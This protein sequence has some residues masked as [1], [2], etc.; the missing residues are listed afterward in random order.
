MSDFF[1]QFFG[2]LGGG[3]SGGGAQF[4]RRAGGGFS[5]F[6][7]G[8][9]REAQKAPD[10]NAEVEIALEDAIK[11]SKRRLE[12]TAQDDCPQCGGSGMVA[13]EE[14]QGKARIVRSTEPC[15]RCGGAGIIPAH[16]TLEVTIPPGVTE[17][18]RI[19]LKGQ[20]GKGPRADLNGDLFLTVRLASHPVFAATG[21]D[22]RCELP[23]WD[24][25]AALGAE[26]TA[27]TLNGRISLKIPAGSQTGRVMRL[28]G[29]GI[30]ARGSESAGDLLYEIKVLA[31]TD[32]TSDEKNLM[33]QF[34]E[35][36]RA[37]GVPDPRVELMPRR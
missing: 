37:R 21:R 20:G 11:G 24:Y 32:M 15:P 28:K 2:G 33:T 17:G 22:L 4:G 5:G 8:G 23:V 9:A 7:F 35:K 36:R 29:R 1:A 14:R 3:F 16:R 12:L 18:T 19:R 13:R 6:N 25:E 27:P 34:A 31:P 26:I 10:L 30:P